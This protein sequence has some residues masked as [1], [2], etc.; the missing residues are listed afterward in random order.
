MINVKF[1]TYRLSKYNRGYENKP[2]SK[3]ESIRKTS[4][5]KTQNSDLKSMF[6]HE[7]NQSIDIQNKTENKKSFED[8]KDTHENFQL[9]WKPHH[10]SDI[11]QRPVNIMIFVNPK[12]SYEHLIET[13]LWFA[14]Y[15][16]SQITISFLGELNQGHQIAKDTET[17]AFNIFGDRN[18]SYKKPILLNINSVDPISFLLEQVAIQN[19]D[20][21]IAPTNEKLENSIAYVDHTLERIVKETSCSLLL[22][23]PKITLNKIKNILIPVETSQFSFPAI[24]QALILADQFHSDLHLLHVNNDNKENEKNKIDL[25][26]I[27][28]VLNFK[29]SPHDFS[30]RNGD[31]TS[32]ILSETKNTESDLIVLGTHT[33]DYLWKKSIAVE[34]AETSNTP[35]WVIHPREI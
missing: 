16:H 24:H 28:Q 23:P 11:T 18:Q 25:L 34:L 8:F 32:V 9:L 20:L 35:L 2:V 13:G 14:K 1:V 17:K 29:N 3:V 19:I 27:L 30:E 4:E 12:H 33:K 7:M 21:L 31:I 6:E 15:Y 5:A 10:L 26:K 22:L